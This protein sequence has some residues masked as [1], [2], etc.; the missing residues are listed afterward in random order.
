MLI[1]LKMQQKL[2]TYEIVLN[3]NIS[4]PIGTIL[5]VEKLD[6]VLDF[7][8]VFCKHKKHAIDINKL[9]KALVSLS[10]QT[11]SAS[12]KLNKSD[13]KILADFDEYCPEIVDPENGIY[14]I[15]ITNPNSV[16]YLYFSEKLQKE[17]LESKGR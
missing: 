16:N 17:Q 7:P 2:R 3:T 15:K 6:D 5:T 9:L 1:R 8:I 13:D 12:K 11:I 10:S 14:E 4:F